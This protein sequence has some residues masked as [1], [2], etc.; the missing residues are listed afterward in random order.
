MWMPV[1]RKIVGM[2]G[3]VGGLNGFKVVAH[4][5]WIRVLARN[6][7]RERLTNRAGIPEWTGDK[8]LVSQLSGLSLTPW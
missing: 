1:D 8:Y 7:G 3:L 6:G 2:L 4:E 5:K